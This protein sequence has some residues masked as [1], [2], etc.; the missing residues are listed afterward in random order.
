MNR[1][2]VDSKKAQKLLPQQ[3]WMSTTTIT[4][5]NSSPWLEPSLGARATTSRARGVS[6]RAHTQRKG[7]P[8]GRTRPSRAREFDKWYRWSSPQY[9]LHRPVLGPPGECEC[10]SEDMH[11]YGEGANPAADAECGCCGGEPYCGY[12]ANDNELSGGTRAAA[13]A[14]SARPAAGMGSESGAAYGRGPAGGE[15]E[16]TC[17]DDGGY[18]RSGEG[19][20]SAYPIS[21]GKSA[22]L[23]RSIIGPVGRARARARGHHRMRYRMP[24]PLR[25][26]L[27]VG[28]PLVVQRPLERKRRVKVWRVFVWN[29]RRTA[30]RGCVRSGGAPLRGGIER[31]RHEEES[32][33][34]ALGEVIDAAAVSIPIRMQL[35]LLLLRCFGGK[36][37]SFIPRID[38]VHVHRPLQPLQLI[39][40]MSRQ[41][42]KETHKSGADGIRAYEKEPAPV[43]TRVYGSATSTAKYWFKPINSDLVLFSP[44]MPA[45]RS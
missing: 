9:P 35:F 25:V 4:T 3:E 16:D 5:N 32:R 22:R 26:A 33:F 1:R 42:N 40:R 24:H 38:E 39:R 29:R 12:A 6:R 7:G 31:E 8:A 30:V 41:S 18:S 10:P 28:I 43:N 45:T 37:H 11:A 20:S 13:G 21:S 17:K 14:A 44:N 34:E 15:E 36:A 27:A 2:K 19:R 23:P